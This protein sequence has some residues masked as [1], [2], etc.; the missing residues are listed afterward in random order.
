M[1]AGAGLL[2]LCS[3]SRRQ[4]DTPGSPTDA[5]MQ[6]VTINVQMGATEIAGDERRDFAIYH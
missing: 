1:A 4:Y 2:A 5:P 3:D 6:R